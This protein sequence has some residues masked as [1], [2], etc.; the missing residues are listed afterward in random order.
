[1]TLQ[2]VIPD[3]LATWPPEVTGPSLAARRLRD[4]LR[5]LASNARPVLVLG[6]TGFSGTAIAATL[7]QLSQAGGSLLTVS[8]SDDDPAA[9]ETALFGGPPLRRVRGDILESVSAGSA[10]LRAQHGT[11]ALDSVHDLPVSA[12]TRLVRILRDGEVRLP[13]NGAGR[14]VRLDLRV[15]AASELTLAQL[16]AEVRQ[17]RF[18]ADLFKRLSTRCVELV[19]LRDRREDIAPVALALVER[20]ANGRPPRPFTDA[21][22][23]LIAALPWEG[24]VASLEAL[25][26]ALLEEGSDAPIRVEDV[27]RQMQ[28]GMVAHVGAPR[29][30]LRDAR[31]Q[32][33]REYIAAVLKHSGWSMGQAAR[34]LGIQRTNLYR[35][36]RQLGIARTKA[37]E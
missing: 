37:G 6:P 14:P 11:L 21:A 9:L 7:H 1:V 20:I 8:C 22:L 16:G 26:R 5:E 17:G 13:G 30:S 19:A 34:V 18:R 29:A 2:R 3:E 27:L 10:V 24:N 32:F 4:R 25:V 33:E 35:K 31:R 23:A 28:P 12:Q 36:A 15:V